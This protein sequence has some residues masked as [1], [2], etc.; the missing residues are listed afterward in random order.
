[1]FYAWF[2]YVAYMVNSQKLNP[3]TDKVLN[4]AFRQPV[5][6]LVRYMEL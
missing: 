2:E 1:M 6:G 5:S 3:V 4:A